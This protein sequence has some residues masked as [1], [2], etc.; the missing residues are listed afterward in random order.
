MNNTFSQLM[1]L[2]LGR[3][4]Y[5]LLWPVWMV[6]FWRNPCR[7]RVM[8][9]NDDK[10]LCVK[11]WISNGKW[12]LPGGGIHEGEDKKQAA[13]REVLEET[14][15]LLDPT[16]CKP[17]IEYDTKKRGINLN[18]T[19]FV[20]HVDIQIEPRSQMP[21]ILCAEWLPISALYQKADSLLRVAIDKSNLIY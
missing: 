8:I 16:D 11:P 15:V 19:V 7:A 17:F 18:E 5:V 21:E 6:Y 20:C 2:C 10:I 9:I 12:S 13:V 14:N 3:C 1:L 4:F